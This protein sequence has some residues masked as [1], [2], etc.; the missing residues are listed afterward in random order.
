MSFIKSHRAGCRIHLS[1]SFLHI[2]VFELT[3]LNIFAEFLNLNSLISLPL[4]HTFS[5][6]VHY[7]DLLTLSAP[8]KPRVIHLQIHYR[9]ILWSS[10]RFRFPFTSLTLQPSDKLV[11]IVSFSWNLCLGGFYHIVLVRSFLIFLFTLYPS[12]A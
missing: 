7:S 2:P 3:V 4:S 1:F 10:L 6:V 9:Y 5:Y 11:L 12:I 8:W